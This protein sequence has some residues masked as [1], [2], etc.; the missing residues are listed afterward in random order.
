MLDSQRLG[1]DCPD[2][3]GLAFKQFRPSGIVVDQQNAAVQW[4]Y[5][6]NMGGA[7]LFVGLRHVAVSQRWPPTTR[8]LLGSCLA[9]NDCGE[10]R[11]ESL[12]L[13][14]SGGHSV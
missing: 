9:L 1:K 8:L 11:I 13:S 12:R 5:F 4:L 2:P 6:S 7:N 3:D 14:G 10:L